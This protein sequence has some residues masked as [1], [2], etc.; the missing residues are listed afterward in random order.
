LPLLKTECSEQSLQQ[1]K[2]IIQ[3]NGYKVAKSGS[4]ADYAF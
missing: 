3:Q 1:T 4:P 2:A